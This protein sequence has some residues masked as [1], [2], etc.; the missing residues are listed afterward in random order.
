MPISPTNPGEQLLRNLLT[1][2]HTGVD[3]VLLLFAEQALIEYPYAASVG[4]PARLTRDE[5]GQYL[6]R[7][8]PQVPD[9]RFSEVRV[10]PLREPSHYVA[11]MYAAATVPGT[12]RPYAQD[13]VLFFTVADGRFTHYREYWNPIPWLRAF[14]SE[15]ALLHTLATNAN[16]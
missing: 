7:V 1:A 4:T 15:Q 6:T 10:Y 2:F 13:Y 12:G 8:L 14:G 11:E 16:Q 5:Y 3:D 9:L